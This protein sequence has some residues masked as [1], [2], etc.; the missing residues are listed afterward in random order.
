MTSTL[1]G[2]GARFSDPSDDSSASAI[3]PFQVRNCSGLGFAPKFR[4]TL[5]GG[6]ERGDHPTLR[7]V[8]TPRQEEANLGKATVTLPPK[9]FLAQENIETIC[10]R[11]AVRRPQLPEGLGLRQRHG[12]HAAAR[13]SR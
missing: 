12:D 13:T 10:T 4:L 7:A 5:K 9:I 11:A 2:A 6:H 1:T 8:D 3:S